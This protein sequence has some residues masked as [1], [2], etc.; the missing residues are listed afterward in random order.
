MQVILVPFDGT[1]H[2]AKALHIACDLADKYGSAIGLVYVIKASLGAP[3]GTIPS[4]NATKRANETLDQAVEKMK[5]RGM[6]PAF[7]AIEYGEPAQSI[8]LVAKLHSVNMIIMGCRGTKNEDNS[9]FGS[10]SQE[11]FYNAVCTCISV[12]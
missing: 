2:S 11:V 5:P 8:L 4:A 9:I 6:E 1:P 10:V 12:K 7:K 3:E